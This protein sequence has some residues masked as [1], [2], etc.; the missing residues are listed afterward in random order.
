MLSVLLSWLYIAAVCLFTG[1]LVWHLLRRFFAGLKPGVTELIVTGAVVITVLAEYIS[2]FT[3][4]RANMQVCC[5]FLACFGA[6]RELGLPRKGS[7]EPGGQA[8]AFLHLQSDGL[9]SCTGNSFLRLYCLSFSACFCPFTPLGETS[10][11]IP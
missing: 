1:C 3:G 5:L 4:I 10:M 2:I 9:I 11:W 7:A 8:K 6:V